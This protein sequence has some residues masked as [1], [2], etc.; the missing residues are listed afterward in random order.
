MDAAQ[1][2]AIRQGTAGSP[3]PGTVYDCFANLWDPK[4]PECAGGIDYAKGSTP[5]AQCPY[6]NLCGKERAVE[7]AEEQLA[8]QRQPIPLPISS[9]TRPPTGGPVLPAI[10]VAPHYA[11]ASPQPQPMPQYSA[12]AAL[13]A[14]ASSQPAA[15]PQP[16]Q[17]VPYGHAQVT[18]VTYIAQDHTMPQYL[19]EPEPLAPDEAVWEALGWELLRGGIKG[20]LHTGAHF[21]D[22]VPFGRRGGRK[23]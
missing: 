19:S 12:L 4:A 22:R 3:T 18:P 7:F 13:A 20:L 17:Q 16:M 2:A 23:T 15:Q 10:S 1:K 11:G 9:L 14:R 5:H 21:V 6:F 8:Q